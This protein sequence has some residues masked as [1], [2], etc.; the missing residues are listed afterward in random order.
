MPIK[1]NKVNEMQ[2]LLLK[3]L[4]LDEKE[5]LKITT[6]KTKSNIIKDI[7]LKH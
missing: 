5:N 3:D 6:N 1:I 4:Q 2:H 7:T